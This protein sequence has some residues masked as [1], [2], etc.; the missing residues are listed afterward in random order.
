MC[1]VIIYFPVYD[2]TIFEISLSF[3]IMLFSKMTK[4]VTTKIEISDKLDEI[5][6]T[7]KKA[8]DVSSVLSNIKKSTG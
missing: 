4:T 3:L 5:S 8:K 2:V 7:L 6:L 1:T